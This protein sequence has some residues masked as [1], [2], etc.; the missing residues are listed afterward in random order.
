MAIQKMLR[1]SLSNEKRSISAR[2]YV[3]KGHFVVYVG[4]S[5]EK[6]RFVIPLTF[7]NHPLFQD[8]LTRAEEEFGFCH[9]TG[10]LAI[11]CS[12]DIF[13]NVTSRLARTA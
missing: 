5:D 4:E 1:R 13:I 10:G 8:L 7:L 9:P 3:P 2:T 11:P 12:E 6:K